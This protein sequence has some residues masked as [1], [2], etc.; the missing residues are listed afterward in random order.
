MI[1]PAVIQSAGRFEV[2]GSGRNIK[3]ND[4]VG[5]N[6]D[7]LFD[8]LASDTRWSPA[9]ILIHIY[10][11]ESG[12]GRLPLQFGQAFL[13]VPSNEP[14]VHPVGPVATKSV[15]AVSRNEPQLLR[16]FHGDVDVNGVPF[17]LLRNDGALKQFSITCCLR[18]LFR[19]GLKPRNAGRSQRQ[20]RS[21]I[22][23]VE[24]FLN[25]TR[26]EVGFWIV[27]LIGLQIF[28]RYF[29]RFDTTFWNFT[30]STP[31]DSIQNNFSVFRVPPVP[32]IVSASEPESSSAAFIH[33]GPSHV[34]RFFADEHC[35]TNV[36]I[37]VV[38]I[39]RT[40]QRTVFLHQGAGWR[41][42]S[43][44][45]NNAFHIR[46]KPHVIVPLVIDRKRFNTAS[47]WMLR[48]LP[49]VGR[50]V[51]IHRPVS[52]EVATHPVEKLP[53]C[54]R[55]FNFDTVVKR[56][57]PN[58][59]LRVGIDLVEMRVD[60]VAATTVAVHDD[61]VKTVERIRIFRPAVSV[62]RCDEIRHRF[63]ERPS[64]QNTASLVLV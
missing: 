51:R 28:E 25:R 44:N 35:F 62:H 47:N 41:K 59:R 58:S 27:V 37:V 2:S 22:P 40:S 36:W 53:T 42:V 17:G 13:T 19:F 52:L 30:L 20:G 4:R 45:R 46:A 38:S 33:R 11:A 48:K 24:L 29:W 14:W 56:N 15:A 64:Q 49:V 3:L 63:S 18:C 21:T 50:P 60:H 5:V 9:R 1:G 26:I 16:S 39:V 34:L 31:H 12:R 55:N 8:G 54:R 43:Q 6:S 7:A 57:N 61:T 32:V 23:C 10:L